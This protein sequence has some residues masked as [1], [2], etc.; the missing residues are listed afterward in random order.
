MP[1]I[2]ATEAEAATAWDLLLEDPAEQEW[3]MERDR[4]AIPAVME[5]ESVKSAP[6][7]ALFS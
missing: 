6:M 7:E 2:P 3:E 5:K 1:A 4:P